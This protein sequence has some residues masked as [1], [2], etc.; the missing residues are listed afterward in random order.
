MS[1]PTFPPPGERRTHFSY[2]QLDL[3]GR[4][5]W[6]Y[7]QRYITSA[8]VPPQPCGSK[9]A[10]L[11]GTVVH[12][13]TEDAGAGIIRTRYA[14]PLPVDRLLA[15][16][17]RKFQGSTLCGLEW[18]ALGRQVLIDWCARLG[19]V[20]RG[21]FLAV[22]QKF[23]LP[24]LPGKPLIGYMDLVG[25]GDPGQKQVVVT[26]YKTGRMLPTQSDVEGS[27]QLGIY[28][29][30]ALRLHPWA[31]RA[32]VRFDMMRHGVILAT[33]YTREQA[34]VVVDYCRTVA[35]RI[36]SQPR[37]AFAPTLNPLCG[38]CD[39]RARCPARQA[40]LTAPVGSEAHDTAS[41]IE[42]VAAEYGGL[43]DRERAIKSRKAELAK[44]LRAALGQGGEEGLTLAGRRYRL[45]T[46]ER[47]THPATATLAAI[48]RFT[49]ADPDEY[50]TIATVSKD[51]LRA[52]LKKIGADQ[53]REDRALLKAE[54][55]AVA[56]VTA[57][58]RLDC[59]KV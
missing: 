58:Q 8:E 17:E 47:R 41:G 51:K 9:N 44:L 54:I 26:D 6:S 46:T 20:T 22:E 38:W 5:G 59:R 28:A 13:T 45:V 31:E 35:Q 56:T 39:H 19:A 3:F 57:G 55:D 48:S 52:T 50:A 21:Q 42:A 25:Q 2:S 10:A 37:D 29:A 32:V 7:D 12:E 53:T 1:E 23:S 11:L 33:T 34:A 18:F 43:T 36:E 30:A 16:Y 24:L 14:G 40:A 15:I 49:G 27:L 4:C